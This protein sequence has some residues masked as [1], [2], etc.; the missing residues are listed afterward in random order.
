MGNE[1]EVSCCWWC[2]VAD[3]L[4]IVIVVPVSYDIVQGRRMPLFAVHVALPIP[5]RIR[6]S[7]VL[8]STMSCRAELF[9]CLRAVHV[10]LP[11]PSRVVPFY[12]KPELLISC[13]SRFRL[14]LGYILAPPG[15]IAFQHYGAVSQ[16]HGI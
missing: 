9:L 2:Q 15:A 13:S 12:D 1:I 7:W 8:Y 16:K 4:R 5:L 6:L 3:R 11:I 10:A 14:S